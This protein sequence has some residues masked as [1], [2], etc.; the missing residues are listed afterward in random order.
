MMSPLVC[1]SYFHSHNPPITHGELFPHKVLL[2]AQHVA[3]ISLGASSKLRMLAGM[4][5]VTPTDLD[6]LPQ[7]ALKFDHVCKPS[8]DIFSFAGIVLY[9]FNQQ[10]PTPPAIKTR[11]DFYT[12]KTIFLSERE[13]RQVH[14]KP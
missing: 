5:N 6:F 13:Q 12:V 9:T 14:L 4:A 11:F 1:A 3:K 2:T 7:E 10:W 8:M